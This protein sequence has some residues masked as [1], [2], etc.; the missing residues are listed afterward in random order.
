MK[1]FVLIMIGACA[2]AFAA[3]SEGHHAEGVPK[4]VLWQ[5]I[6][7]GLIFAFVIYK[8]KDKITHLFKARNTT[9]LSEFQKS[10][11][12]KSEAEKKLSEIR[13][14]IAHLENT[15]EEGVERARAEAA[16]LRKQMIQEAKN[17][18]EK[19]KREAEATAQ[20]EIQ[21][22]K[23]ALHEEIVRESVRQAKEILKKDM[24]QPDQIRL[25]DQFSNQIETVRLGEIR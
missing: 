16:D 23:R 1:L 20:V 22:A 9:F 24:G 6:N 17:L 11:S 10:Q 19:I 12:I 3:G 4:V 5:A 8:F 2:T 13:H 25:Q 7:L 15:A 21:S 14:K 18:A